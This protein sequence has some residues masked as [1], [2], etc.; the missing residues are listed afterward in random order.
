[1][2]MQPYGQPP[3]G[4]VQEGPPPPGYGQTAPGYGQPTPGYGQPAP[5]Y[6]QPAPGYGQPAPGYGQPAQPGYAQ[7][8]PP[9][10]A[11]PPA[12]KPQGGDDS[13]G[14]CSTLNIS[15]LF[16]SQLSVLL[17]TLLP[18]DTPSFTRN[19]GASLRTWTLANVAFLYLSRSQLVLFWTTIYR[20]YIKLYVHFARISRQSPPWLKSEVLTTFVMD[21]RGKATKIYLHWDGLYLNP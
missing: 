4:Y 9:Q 2:A 19:Y 7:Q 21:L 1:M 15:R 20:V 12:P 8:P 11:A 13:D 6:G 5:G 3:P 18:K 10:Q 14:K 17:S 16:F